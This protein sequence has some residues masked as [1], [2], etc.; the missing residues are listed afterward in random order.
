MILSQAALLLS[1]WYP[2]SGTGPQ[3]PNSLWLSIAIHHARCL[4]ADEAWEHRDVPAQSEESHLLRR[5]WWCCVI[6]DRVVSLGFRQR[7][8]ITRVP[9]VLLLSDFENEIN[10]SEVTRPES[11]RK[12]VRMLLRVMELCEILTDFL[13]LICLP[14]CYRMGYTQREVATL[15]GCRDALQKWFMV[16][17]T[18]IPNSHFDNRFRDQSVIV[19]GSLMYMYY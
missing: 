5:L 4:G 11:K 2:M 13:E 12:L 19:H 18:I 17:N 16:T 3:K 15:S 8:Q 10:H 7:L 1:F 14:D 6:R 9:P